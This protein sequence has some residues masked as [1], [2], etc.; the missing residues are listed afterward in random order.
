M[1]MACPC[2]RT[3]P[4]FDRASHRSRITAPLRM[5]WGPAVKAHRSAN[6]ET[7]SLSLRLRLAPSGARRVLFGFCSAFVRFLFGLCSVFVRV[8]FHPT[9]YPLE[10]LDG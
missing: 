6:R 3:S 7:P 8:I 9:C 2:D 10:G 4:G 5:L 1:T